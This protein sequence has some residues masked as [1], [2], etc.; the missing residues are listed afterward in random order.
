[1]HR[2]GYTLLLLLD[3]IVISLCSLCNTAELS[4]KSIAWCLH[5]LEA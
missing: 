2:Y 5:W 1:M 4:K 3:L